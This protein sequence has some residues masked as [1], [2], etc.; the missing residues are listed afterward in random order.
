MIKEFSISTTGGTELIDITSKVAGVV[1]GSKIKEGVAVVYVPHTTA[2]ITINENA[3][4]SVKRDIL[5]E[6]NKIIP[7]NDNYSHAEGNSAAHIKASLIGS[8]LTVIITGGRLLLGTWQ[9]IYFCEFDGPRR[10]K[11]FVKIVKSEE[12]KVIK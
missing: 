12:K 7:F 5:M 11:V 3:D 9:G 1:A 10:R 8:S 4:P 6:L 2:G